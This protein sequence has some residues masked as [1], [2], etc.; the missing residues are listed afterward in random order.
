MTASLRICRM[1]ITEY[2]DGWQWQQDTAAQVRQGADD[3]LALLQHSPVYTI[4]RRFR[5]EHLLISQH[6]LTAVGAD[7]VETNRGGSITFHGPGQIVG[8]PILNLRRAGLSPR[9]FVCRLEETLIRTLASF[10]IQGYRIAGRPGVW[11]KLGKIA[12]IG[13]RVERGTTLHGFALNVHIDLS[14]F[15]AIIPCGIQGATVTSMAQL[16]DPN[17]QYADVELA[18]ANNF[19]HLFGY[20]TEGRMPACQT[21]GAHQ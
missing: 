14:N 6:E 9:N 21:V 7:V 20:S 10:G 16:L 4:G 19:L 3:T 15:D 12:A 2:L 13:A 5:S 1:P 8:Y 17:P 11:T 18:L